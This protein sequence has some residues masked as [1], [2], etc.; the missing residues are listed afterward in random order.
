MQEKVAAVAAMVRTTLAFPDGSPWMH[1]TCDELKPLEDLLRFAGFNDEAEL[2]VFG[3]AYGDDDPSDD[4]HDLYGELMPCNCPDH[5]GPDAMTWS[6]EDHEPKYSAA[7]DRLCSLLG[8]EKDSDGTWCDPG[9]R[10]A[11]LSVRRYRRL[12][13]VGHDT[14]KETGR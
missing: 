13:R 4:H 8:M 5:D 7:L 14:K 12:V 11:D 10:R 3:H 2:L 9:V 1:L 6:P